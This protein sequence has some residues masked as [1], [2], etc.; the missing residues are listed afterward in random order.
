M[1][2]IM[3]ET[4]RLAAGEVTFT[5]LNSGDLL[6]ATSGTTMLNQLLGNPIDGSLNNLFLRVHGEN[7]KIQSF[8]LLGVHS[9]SQVSTSKSHADRQLIWTGSVE[10]DHAA[11]AI[12]YEVVFTLA[13]QGIWFWNVKITGQQQRIDV[14]Y[15]Q[16]VD[17]LIRA[18][19]GVMKHTCH[20][21]STILYLKMIPKDT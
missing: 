19:F 6:Q 16:D 21:I 17:S 11:Q 13:P 3:N 4:I 12:H 5:F 10:P 15:G 9:G 1:T 20:N 18:Q 2:T 8:P 14:V 7:G